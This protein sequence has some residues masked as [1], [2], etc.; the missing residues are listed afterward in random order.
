MADERFLIARLSSLGDVIFTLPVL[1]AL[2]DSFPSSKI[3][4]AIE[5]RWQPL[6]AENPDLDEAIPVHGRSVTGFL[7]CA[8]ELR[9][10]HYTCAI[11]IQGLYKSALLARLSGAPRRIGLSRQAARE[12]GAST[13]YTE[14][15]TPNAAHMVDKNLVLA[16]A[17]GARP[18]PVRFPLHVS[19]AQRAAVRQM[20]DRAGM[21]RYVVLSIGGGWQSKCWPPDRFRELSSRLRDTYQTGIVI[22][23]GPGEADLARATAA[24]ETAHQLA[25]GEGSVSILMALLAGA[26][27]VIA[28]DSGPLHL[29][30]AL[31]TPVI[32]L[33]GPTNPARNGP[34]GGR[35]IV[36]RSEAAETTYKRG[37]SYSDSMLSI[38]VDQVMAA[39]ERLAGLKLRGGDAIQPG[40]RS[41]WNLQQGMSTAP[42]KRP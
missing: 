40:E 36:I 33:Y 30:A 4:W 25:F 5:E 19:D 13:L 15:V 31:G 16:A 39:V 9:R 38:S 35:G 17:A 26:D 2:R 22:N 21:R 20:L 8:R 27:L 32:G 10:R 11:D 37:D 14:R 41:T 1:A 12:P 28:A 42:G 7:R 34:Y 29:A 18:N 23:A 6:L 3:D 24:K